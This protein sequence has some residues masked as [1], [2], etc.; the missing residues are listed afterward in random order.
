MLK[1][2]TNTD[3]LTY[4]DRKISK[5]IMGDIQPGSLVLLNGESDTG[6][7]ILCQQLSYNV[8]YNN[9][10]SVAYFTSDIKPDD[11]LDQMESFSFHVHYHFVSDK[12]RISSLKLITPLLI[13]SWRTL[14]SS[15]YR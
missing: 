10:S 5:L 4:G 3:G 12:F 6:K 14:S 13:R 11:L 9:T 8:L 1:V 2:S 15:R 7:S